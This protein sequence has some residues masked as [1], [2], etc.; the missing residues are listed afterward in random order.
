MRNECT[1][2]K[3]NGQ[4]AG[5][6]GAESDLLIESRLLPLRFAAKDKY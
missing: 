2:Y 4:V 3:E 6:G 5:D 1:G